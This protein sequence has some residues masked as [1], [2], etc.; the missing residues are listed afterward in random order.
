MGE[1]SPNVVP[2]RWTFTKQNKSNKGTSW[3]PVRGLSGFSPKRGK[4]LSTTS[5]SRLMYPSFQFLDCSTEP[6]LVRMLG[7]E[8][9]IVR[10]E[11]YMDDKQKVIPEGANFASRPEKLQPAVDPALYSR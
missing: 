4:F 3:N 9:S 8:T 11:P 1:S 7:P 2:G 6:D 10:S 5:A